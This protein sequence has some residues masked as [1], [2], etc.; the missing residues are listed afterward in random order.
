MHVSGFH[1]E[2]RLLGQRQVPTKTGDGHSQFI[3]GDSQRCSPKDLRSVRAVGVREHGSCLDC[4]VASFTP[5]HASRHH[6]VDE[7]VLRFV[8]VDLFQHRGECKA[9]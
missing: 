8:M 1:V 3:L 4:R 5:W 6:V 7:H 9:V 2:A